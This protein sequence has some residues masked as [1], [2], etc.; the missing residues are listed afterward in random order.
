MQ[1]SFARGAVTLK[2]PTLLVLPAHGRDTA[3]GDR[4]RETRARSPSLSFSLAFSPFV[5]QLFA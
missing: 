2:V 3:Q 5:Q 1:G 4:D